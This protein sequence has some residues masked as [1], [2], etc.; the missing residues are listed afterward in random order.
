MPSTAANYECTGN[1]GCYLAYGLWALGS[2]GATMPL[3]AGLPA[4]A[5]SYDKFVIQ[6]QNIMVQ[7]STVQCSAVQYGTVQYGTA[8]LSAVQYCKVR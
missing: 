8:G 4:G 2:T 6:V 1:I 3:E 7:F 5:G